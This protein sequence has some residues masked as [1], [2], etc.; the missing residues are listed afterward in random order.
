MTHRALIHAS[1]SRYWKPTYTVWV[2]DTERPRFP[3]AD[4]LAARYHVVKMLGTYRSNKQ[5][6]AA[7]KEAGLD[8]LLNQRAVP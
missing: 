5:A 2:Y 7:I 6:Y 3:D 1:I 4:F 8:L